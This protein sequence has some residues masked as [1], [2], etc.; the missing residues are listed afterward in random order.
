[1]DSS[2]INYYQTCVKTLL[3]EYE[4]HQTECST[5]ETIFDDKQMRYIALRVGWNKQRRIHYCLIHIDI[6]EENVVIQLNNTEDALD[7]ELVALGIPREKIYPG[8]LPPNV[9]EQLTRFSNTVKS[10]TITECVD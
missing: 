3:S 10:K 9:Q 5:V 2:H 1:M 8:L 7:D 4:T 6:Q